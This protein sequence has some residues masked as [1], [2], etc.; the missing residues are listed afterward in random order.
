[1]EGWG[2]MSETYIGWDGKQYPWPPPEGWYEAID[3]RYWAPG[4]GPNPP[5]LGAGTPGDAAADPAGT[6]TAGNPAAGAAGAPVIGGGGTPVDAGLTSQLP[7]QDPTRATVQQPLGGAQPTPNTFNYGTAGGPEGA[8]GV[9]PV[10]Q[11]EKRGGG[12]LQAILIVFGMVA[13][14]ILGGL[15]YFYLTSDSGESTATD[16][17]TEVD[18]GDDTTDDTVEPA[19]E[20]TPDDSASGTTAAPEDETEEPAPDDTTET[21]TPDEEPEEETTTTE[22]STPELGQF[23]QILN[24][25]G[26][27]SENLTDENINSFAA[28]FCGMAADAIDEADFDL[29]RESSVEATNSDLSDDELRLVINAAIVAFCPDQA[30]RLNIQP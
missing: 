15:G 17:T 10:G 6:A 28:S 3:G 7:V 25:N 14:A 9:G 29:T 12:I 4:T 13:V 5:P 22:A 11:P 8:P 23:R 20:T 24:D 2:P 16:D 21:S 18:A 27:T 1:M 30:D 26:L 19:D